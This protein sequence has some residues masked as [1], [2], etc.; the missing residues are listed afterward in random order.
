L[1]RSS[2]L[3]E[4]DVDKKTAIR[5]AIVIVLALP[6]AIFGGMFGFL[7]GSFAGDASPPP[8][9]MACIVSWAV[10]TG[11]CLGALPGLVA[12][13]LM[14]VRWVIP[15]L[16][17]G[18]GALV[19]GAVIVAADNSSR[20]FVGSSPLNAYLSGIIMVGPT[21]VGFVLGILWCRA[22]IER[23]R[24]RAK[25]PSAALPMEPAS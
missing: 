5:W 2:A 11:V 12:G 20:H 1:E 13:I 23:D 9:V 7:V 14:Q 25:E 4:V 8:F 18:L 15:L 6:G 10:S 21:I 22:L 19:S 17:A 24:Q 16:T 3:L